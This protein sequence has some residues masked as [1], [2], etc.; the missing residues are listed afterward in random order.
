MYSVKDKKMCSVSSSSGPSQT[1]LFPAIDIDHVCIF[2]VISNFAFFPPVLFV[3]YSQTI[4]GGACI[5]PII[6]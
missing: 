5:I 6:D 3:A 4:R 2:K 1:E